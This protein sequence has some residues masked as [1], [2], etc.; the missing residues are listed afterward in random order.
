MPLEILVDTK[1][2]KG[3]MKLSTLKR[4]DKI[5]EVIESFPELSKPVSIVN[6]VK[7][8]KQAYYKGNLNTINSLHHKSKI[9]SLNTLK[10]L[11]E[12]P[13]C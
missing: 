5:N 13:I 10:T 8:S 2:E 1:K 11:M 4:M 6:L 12:I 7:Y 3:V 9:T